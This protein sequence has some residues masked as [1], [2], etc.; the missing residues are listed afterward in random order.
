[1]DENSV[2]RLV[3]RVG[4][5]RGHSSAVLESASGDHLGSPHMQGRGMAGASLM[6]VL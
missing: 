4:C 2:V 3:V 5:G 6:I 1:M